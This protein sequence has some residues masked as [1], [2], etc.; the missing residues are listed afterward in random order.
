MHVVEEL[1]VFRVQQ[2]PRYEKVNL[3]AIEGTF[4]G[5]RV[6]DRRRGRDDGRSGSGGI[7][8]RLFTRHMRISS[9]V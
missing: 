6:F 3:A 5:G 8:Y 2:A 7:L 4:D 1:V 9:S